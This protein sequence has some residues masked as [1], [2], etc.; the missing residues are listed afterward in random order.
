M[1]IIYRF[2]YTLIFLFSLRCDAYCFSNHI[3]INEELNEEKKI[4]NNTVNELID[5]K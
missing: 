4:I 1:Y 5:K 3:N 2:L